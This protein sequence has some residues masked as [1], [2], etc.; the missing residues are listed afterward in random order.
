MLERLKDGKYAGGLVSDICNEVFAKVEDKSGGSEDSP[1]AYHSC[2]KVM[3]AVKNTPQVGS[4]MQ[5]G[6]Y[7]LNVYG[8][9]ELVTPCPTHAI[10][11]NLMD[12]SLAE[13]KGFCPKCQADSSKDH[14]NCS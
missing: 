13:G 8:G 1:K 6:C 3:D 14:T 9:M 5:E 11:G 12:N 4:W 2:F 10:C 7:K